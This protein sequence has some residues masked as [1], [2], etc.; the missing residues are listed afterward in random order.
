MGT[1][2]EQ[3][4]GNSMNDIAERL[5][6]SNAELVAAL[7]R[8]SWALDRIGTHLTALSEI[9]PDDK[10]IECGQL[11]KNESGFARAAIA[12]AAEVKS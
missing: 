12:K 9:D 7:Q 10:W 1:Q 6:A 3:V 11:V 2:L 5:R 4:R 8:A